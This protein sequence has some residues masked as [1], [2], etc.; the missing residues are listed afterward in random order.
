[1]LPISTITLGWV[2]FTVVSDCQ[3]ELLIQQVLRTAALISFSVILVKEETV[4]K[5]K[6][7]VSSA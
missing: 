4:Y 6:C 2:N 5:K 3:F 1:M 7:S